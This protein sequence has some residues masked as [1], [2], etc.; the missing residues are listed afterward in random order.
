MD[1]MFYMKPRLVQGYC[2]LPKSI[3][4]KEGKIQKKPKSYRI[5]IDVLPTP[6]LPLTKA[7]TLKPR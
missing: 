4:R 3:N 7:R 1:Y 5:T 2:S 6:R